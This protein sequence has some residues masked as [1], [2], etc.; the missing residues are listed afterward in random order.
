MADI[1]RRA[2]NIGAASLALAGVSAGRA[3]AEDVTIV[4]NGSGGSLAEAIKK[5]FEDPFTAATGIKVRA[6]APVSL[7]KLK[8]MVESG[9][10]EWDLTE[11][12]GDDVARASEAGWLEPLDYSIIDPENKLPEMAKA[13][14][15]MVR[16]SYST[17][18]AYRTDRFEGKA[19]KTWADFWDVKTFPGPRSL[20]NSPKAN[21]EFALLAAGVPK[22]QIYPI[23]VDKAFAKLDEIKE[24]IPV[25]WD[26]GAQHVQLLV[27]GEVNMTSCWNGRITPLK[28]EGKPVDISWEGGALMLSY[29]GIPKGAKHPKEAMQFM[30]FRM[31]PK[32]SAEFVK[33][34]P[35]PGFV[36]GMM[37][38]LEPEF[39]ATL[40]TA[41][42]N[43]AVQFPFGAA[44]WAQNLEEVQKR[45]N[46]WMLL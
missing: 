46:E 44:W 31:D 45:W 21:L 29:L 23:D 5:L 41:P 17:V 8:A 27:D 36:P 16:A 10:V 24:H 26:N 22:E 19:P 37:E 43:A 33:L 20:E 40:P 30:K 1:S 35:Y 6:T 15:A 42:E 4:V 3:A 12:N 7:P 38:L 25:W 2:F 39:V 34:V 9:N 28:K 32:A 14:D 13:R 18:L 11:L